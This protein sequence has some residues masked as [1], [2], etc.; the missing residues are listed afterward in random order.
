MK[1]TNLEINKICHSIV[2]GGEGCWHIED[3]SKQTGDSMHVSI[4]SYCGE[5]GDMLWEE[6]VTTKHYNPDYLNN[7][8]DWADI[9]FFVVNEWDKRNLDEFFAHSER[10]YVDMG[11][12]SDDPTLAGGGEWVA[13]LTC[14]DGRLFKNQKAL[15]TALALY[16]KEKEDGD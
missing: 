4:K 5:C 8:D 9:L 15:P 10:G 11:L 16:E 3:K 7:K 1:L 13:V 14:L 6:A 2:T 12:E